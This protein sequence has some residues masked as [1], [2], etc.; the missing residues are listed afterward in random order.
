MI[1]LEYVD[2]SN[3]GGYKEPITIERILPQNL[4]EN[5]KWIEK[6]SEEEM[7]EWKNKIAILF[8]SGE[9]RIF[10]LEL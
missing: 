10:I 4:P 6:F 9:K 5:S 2:K 1:D 7:Q 3:F 8:C